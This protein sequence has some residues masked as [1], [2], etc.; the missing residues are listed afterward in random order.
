MGC[1]PLNGL[2]ACCASTAM[3]AGALEMEFPG[4][5]DVEWFLGCASANAAETSG[6]SKA[7]EEAVQPGSSCL[8]LAYQSN[9]LGEEGTIASASDAKVSCLGLVGKACCH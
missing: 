1:F 2:G 8:S 4:H 6:D 3:G 7:I 5:T 9:A